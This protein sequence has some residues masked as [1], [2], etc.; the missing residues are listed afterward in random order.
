MFEAL[1]CSSCCFLLT[2]FSSLSEEEDEDA[3]ELGID[4][5]EL[6][7]LKSS[8]ALLN[9]GNELFSVGDGTVEEA[10]EYDVGDS[11]DAELVD[12]EFGM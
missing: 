12:M 4:L 6:I 2:N 11:S 9:V 7:I 3:D 5:R 8:G 10:D 1:T